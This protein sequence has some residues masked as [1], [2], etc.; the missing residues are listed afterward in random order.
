MAEYMN[1]WINREKCKWESAD[2]MKIEGENP[3]KQRNKQTKQQ[4]R[5]Q[6]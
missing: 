5:H 6:P 1:K 2:Q 4:Q 3:E